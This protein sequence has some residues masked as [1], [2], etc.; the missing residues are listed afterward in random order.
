MTPIVLYVIAVVTAEIHLN[1]RH[2]QV[3]A[4]QLQAFRTC[5][6]LV[7]VAFVVFFFFCGDIHEPLL[8]ELPFVE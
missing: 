5:A 3:S 8:I 7:L 4:P 2:D 1:V 6:K